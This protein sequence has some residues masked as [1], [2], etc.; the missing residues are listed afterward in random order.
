MSTYVFDPAWQMERDRL[1]ALESLFDGASTRHLVR[2]GVTAGWRCLEVGCGAGG[3]ARWLARRVGSSGRVVATDLDIRFVEGHD[4]GNLE[5]RKHD[6]MTDAL[7]AGAFDLAHARAVIMHIPDHQGALERV[8][9]AVRP[10]GRVMIEDLDFGGPMATALARYSFPAEHAPLVGRI[11]R[12][13]EMVLSAAGADSSF[14]TRLLAG[15]QAAGLEQVGG[16]VHT[17]VVAGGT[18]T[19]VRGS[20]QQLAARM[21]GTGLVSADEVAS[22]LA[23]ATDGSSHYTPPFMVT[24][25][26]RR[27]PA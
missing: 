17:S 7:E 19:W 3:I 14:G 4:L 21:E 5:V 8:V 18:E 16:E 11:Y 24:A 20:I 9:A 1:R 10:G 22:F 26:G 27:P 23:L 25:W 15:L 12:A 13:A 6:I 2:L